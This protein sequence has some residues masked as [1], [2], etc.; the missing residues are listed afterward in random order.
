MTLYR[1][2]SHKLDE[3]K[4]HAKANGCGA[5]FYPPKWKSYEAARI[6]IKQYIESR[7]IPGKVELPPSKNI[8]NK[9]YGNVGPILSIAFNENC[10][11]QTGMKTGIPNP[12]NWKFKPIYSFDIIGLKSY[13]LRD[14]LKVSKPRAKMGFK[15]SNSFRKGKAPI[16]YMDKPNLK[17][18]KYFGLRA[19]AGGVE[20][21]LFT[22][23]PARLINLHKD[24]VILP[25]KQWEKKT[26]VK[27]GTVADMIKKF[28]K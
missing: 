21:C 3:I 13:S 20:L 26:T 10:A 19:S 27:K 2:D 24:G 8:Y 17:N 5:G 6:S 4:K 1:S 15:P 23:V 11:G 25:K 7:I 14:L 12:H 18:A 9:I 22:P 28:Q 16:L